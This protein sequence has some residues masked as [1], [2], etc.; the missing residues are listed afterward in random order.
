[1]KE[2]LDSNTLTAFARG[3][4]HA[5][6]A[7]FDFYYTELRYFTEKVI[8]DKEEAKD[9]TIETFT[10][11]F[12][13][14]EHFN[15]PQNIKA[16]LFITARNHCLDYLRHRKRLQSYEKDLRMEMIARLENNQNYE[17]SVIEAGVIIKIYEAVEQLPTECKKVFKML[18]YQGLEQAEVASNL[19]INISTVRSHKSRALQLLRISLANNDVSLLYLLL[20]SYLPTIWRTIDCR[21][22]PDI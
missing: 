18:Y 2:Q 15:T 14:Y 8:S 3:D 5:F 20:L 16:F 22:L 6:K 9:I 13:R 21:C 19:E 11:L 12:N 1:M 4:H 7:V 10:K 17:N